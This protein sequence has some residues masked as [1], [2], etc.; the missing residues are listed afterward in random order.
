M[1]KI[2]SEPK[3]DTKYLDNFFHYKTVCI[4][5]WHHKIT[6]AFD[7]SYDTKKTFKQFSSFLNISELKYDTKR[8]PSH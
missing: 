5:M 6:D 8:W 3:Y 1:Q 7:K 2:H 4:K